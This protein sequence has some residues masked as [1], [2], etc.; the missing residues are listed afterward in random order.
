MSLQSSVQTLTAFLAF[1]ILQLK[2]KCDPL[3]K[4]ILKYDA[5]ITKEL[6]DT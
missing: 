3:G 5:L 1:T 4:A 6:Y 2:A